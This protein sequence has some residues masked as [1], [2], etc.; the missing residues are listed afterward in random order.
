MNPSEKG[1]DFALKQ[2]RGAKI[3]AANSP[4]TFTVLIVEKKNDFTTEVD[5]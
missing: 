2:Y 1:G 5:R 3:R 4:P